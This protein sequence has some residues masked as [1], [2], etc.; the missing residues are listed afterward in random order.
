MFRLAVCITQIALSVVL[1][2][3]G[4][5]E[6]LVVSVLHGLGLETGVSSAALNI[7]RFSGTHGTKS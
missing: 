2:G 5:R 6:W 4:E 3:V 7:M 1:G